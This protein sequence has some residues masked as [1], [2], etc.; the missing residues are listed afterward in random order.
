MT[1]KFQTIHAISRMN[2]KTIARI[3]SKSESSMKSEK[4]SK[5]ANGTKARRTD[6][7]WSE[8]AS[9]QRRKQ[10]KVRYDT[11]RREEQPDA[12]D[13]RIERIYF[14]NFLGEKK[15]DIPYNSNNYDY[16]QI[17]LNMCDTLRP[18]ADYNGKNAPEPQ[19]ETDPEPQSETDSTCDDDFYTWTRQIEREKNAVYHFNLVYDEETRT[20]SSDGGWYFKRGHV[21]GEDVVAPATKRAKFYN[22]SVIP[23][24]ASV[25]TRQP[26]DALATMVAYMKSQIKLAQEI[27]SADLFPCD[28][29]KK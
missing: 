26:E 22:E 28:C 25:E 15:T 9:L 5:N 17:N 18:D 3:I 24:I 29:K 4:K 21:D 16:S 12:E 14:A 7:Y 11:H 19:S 2:S 8:D 13:E 27:A 6:A 20:L 23:P 1:L 10:G